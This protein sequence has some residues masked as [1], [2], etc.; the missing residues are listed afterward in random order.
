MSGKKMKWSRYLIPGFIFQSVMIGGGYGTGAEIAQY[1]GTSGMIGGLL[2]MLVTMLVWCLLCA[3]T[4]EFTR[5]FKTYD[6]G[7]MMRQLLGKAGFLYDICYYIMMLIVLGVVNA[8]AGSM[9]SSLTGLSPWFGIIVL[10][11]GIILLVL[12]GTEAIEKVLSFWSYVLY[13]VY[14]LFLIVVFVKF[15]SN[16]GAEFAKGEIGPNWLS[17]GLQYSFYN[18]VV[19]P[20]VLY[21]VR[22]ANSRKE[23]VGCGIL[24]GVIAIVPGILLLLVMGCNMAEVVAA[25]TPVTVIFDM[26]NM[27]WL[28]V[29]F[30]IV[31]F[32]TLIETGTGF[33]KAV[34][35]RIEVAVG[36]SGKSAPA[37]M[38]P[39]IT[40]GMTVIGVCVS[41]F[42]LTN[43]IL[44]GYGTAC[45]GFLIL[46]AIPMLTIGIYKI[47]KAGKK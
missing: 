14:I 29:L 7:S 2:G 40:V 45:Y 47:S 39:A 19:V 16:I 21:T 12:R 22:D 3:V 38:H 6:Y 28:Y 26:L 24:S 1:F 10:S 31:L 46:F 5:V 20:L 44:K 33:I 42:G 41:T 23:A 25:E 15:G 11:I 43:L 34:T 27:K 35:D 30:E 36:R 13:A 37:W 18:L 4:F 32:G 17:S 8:T 9:I